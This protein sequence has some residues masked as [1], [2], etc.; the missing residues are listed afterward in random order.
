MG[1]YATNADVESRLKNWFTVPF[2]DDTEPTD[3]TVSD[4]IDQVEAEINGVLSAQGYSTIP[5]AGA[6][7]VKMLRRYV[8]QMTAVLVWQEFYSVPDDDD[9]PSPFGMWIK[10]YDTFMRALR[11]GEQHL[12]DQSP[13]SDDDPVFMVVRHPQRDD[14]FTDRRYD[15]AD[16]DE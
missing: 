7:D 6:N 10:A 16:W 13:Q 9:I 1:S 8:A 3:D 15:A 2:A 12:I 4:Y 11:R 5:A 14:T